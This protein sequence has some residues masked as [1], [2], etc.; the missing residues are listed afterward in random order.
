M[1]RKQG[2]KKSVENMKIDKKRALKHQSISKPQKIQ[3]RK[4]MI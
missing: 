1:L 3:N 2:M 4:V